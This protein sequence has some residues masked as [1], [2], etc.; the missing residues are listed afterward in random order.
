LSFLSALALFGSLLAVLPFVAH[1]LRRRAA[2][3][4]PFGPVHL[5]SRSQPEARR[6]A[7]LEDRGVFAVR[8]LSVLVLA[9]LGASPFVR[10][11]RLSLSRGGASVALALVV[12]DSLSMRARDVAPSRS[13][14]CR[15]CVRAT[16][17]PLCLR[18]RPPGWRYRPPAISMRCAPHSWR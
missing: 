4:K 13:I 5:L 2:A 15:L 10:C 16:K 12:D 7:R 14:C 9:L 18:G 8:V 11:S 17:S 3:P 6:R 1:R